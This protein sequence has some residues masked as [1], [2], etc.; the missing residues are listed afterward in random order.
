MPRRARRKQ[1]A[2]VSVYVASALES[3]AAEV[4]TRT[5]V[6]DDEPTGRPSAAHVTDDYRHLV[7]HG[8]R[9][10]ALQNITAWLREE[11][12]ATGAAIALRAGSDIVCVASAGTAPPV[13]VTI[14]PSSGISGACLQSGQL[15]VC[16]DAATDPRVNRAAGYYIRSI[17]VS[18]VK[19]DD[20][21]EGIVEI[22]SSTPYAFDRNHQHAVEHVAEVVSTGGMRPKAAESRP[23]LLPV[24][25]SNTD[26]AAERVTFTTEQ[27][28]SA[29]ARSLA[30]VKKV[31]TDFQARPIKAKAIA[32]VAPVLLGGV[33]MV[34]SVARTSS[35]AVDPAQ[36]VASAVEPAPA[37]SSELTAAAAVPQSDNTELTTQQAAK[38]AKKKSSTEA[39]STESASSDSEKQSTITLQPVQQN[40]LTAQS[41]E[42]QPVLALATPP[43][44]TKVPLLGGAA[45]APVLNAVSQRSGGELIHKVTPSYPRMALALRLSGKVDLMATVGT[46]GKVSKVRVI[47]G[48][49]QF[50]QAAVE[51][52]S[53]WRYKPL[54]I[55]GRPTTQDLPVT[56]SFK[57]RAE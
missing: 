11:T 34:W 3:V 30:A 32:F 28:P 45:P 13:G 38:A 51:A 39:P 52:V 33:L 41:K 23:A 27:S 37:A 2:D 31:F 48:E 10:T 17:V 54:L 4:P 55:D 8:D 20:H 43:S 6:L 29:V 46:N 44:A 12:H 26:V 22:L 1:L 35:P 14:D 36:P 56:V 15:T 5:V 7:E 49:P 53:Q 57:P 24:S 19:T 25:I 21:M 9:N 16:D 18:P 40:L 42:E 47:G 50:V